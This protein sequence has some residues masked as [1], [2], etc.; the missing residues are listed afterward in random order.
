RCRTASRGAPRPRPWSRGGGGLCGV[1]H[2]RWHEGGGLRRE[3][4]LGYWGRR[5][6]G[7][8]KISAEPPRRQRG[9]SPLCGGCRAALRLFAWPAAAALRSWHRARREATRDVSLDR[10]HGDFARAAVAEGIK[11]ASGQQLVPVRIAA[12]EHSP[13]SFWL[14]EKRAF[15]IRSPSTADRHSYPP[16][17][18]LLTL[19]DRSG[20]A[21]A[22]AHNLL[23]RQR[24]I[25]FNGT[26]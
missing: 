16:K 12:P 9:G 14:D 23:K 6:S 7:R 19:E 26:P 11:L 24:I 22:T 13:C 3:G 2:T 4:R 20:C 10:F 17:G 5:C 8:T 18:R 25:P 21:G 15:P 1:P